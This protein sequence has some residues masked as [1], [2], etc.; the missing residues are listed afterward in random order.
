[1]R[2]KEKN[3]AGEKKIDVIEK[4]KIDV[5]GDKQVDDD[6]FMGEK[7]RNCLFNF[8]LSLSSGIILQDIF[9][10]K[11]KLEASVHKKISIRGQIIFK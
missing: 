11:A 8:N 4:R 1:M 3:V 5:V 6:P 2:G 9:L 7:K 10:N